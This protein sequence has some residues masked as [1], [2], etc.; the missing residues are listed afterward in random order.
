MTRRG[1]NARP[2]DDTGS[3]LPLTAFFAF[4]SLVLIVVVVA[5]TSLYL[6]RTRLF[7]LADAA[8]LVGAEAYDLA[9]VVPTADGV[10]APLESARVAEAA[11]SYLAAQ[12]S[13]IEALR[14]ERAFTPD[15]ASAE[16]TLSGYWRPPILTLVLPEGVRLEVTAT[17]RSVFG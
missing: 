12:P 9:A 3:I 16:V 13:R 2:T 10:L 1:E 5:A 17:A 15:G 8:A 4:L 11:A 6:E 7:S 14:V